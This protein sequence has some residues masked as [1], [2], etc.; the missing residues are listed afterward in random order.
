[1]KIGDICSNIRDKEGLGTLRT[2]PDKGLNLGLIERRRANRRKLLL[3]TVVQTKYQGKLYIF[4]VSMFRSIVHRCSMAIH[5]PTP[6][7]IS[8]DTDTGKIVKYRPIPIPI[9]VDHYIFPTLRWGDRGQ[10]AGYSPIP[11]ASMAEHKDE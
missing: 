6:I 5:Q 11:L 8:A 4:K 7:L 10:Q 2:L 9:S 3:P 1:M